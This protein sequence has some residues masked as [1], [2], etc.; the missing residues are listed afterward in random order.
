MWTCGWVT[1]LFL[2][3]LPYCLVDV[4]VV[5]VSFHSFFLCSAVGWNGAGWVSVF[6]SFRF[7]HSFIPSF[8]PSFRLHIIPSA[9]L[10]VVTLIGE[11]QKQSF[12]LI[13]A[14]SA[15]ASRDYVYRCNSNCGYGSA[16]SPISAI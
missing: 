7:F 9:S 3:S 16:I 5:H 2:F 4:S 8:L 14:A 12:I 11:R 1:A 15:L 6:L 10:Y 13:L